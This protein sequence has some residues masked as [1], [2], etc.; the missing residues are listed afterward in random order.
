MYT[1]WNEL[2]SVL[3]MTDLCA[4]NISFYLPY[5]YLISREFN[6]AIFAI[7]K[8]IREIKVA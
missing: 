7:E 2:D 1:I 4:L 8:K 3:R 5:S 6:F